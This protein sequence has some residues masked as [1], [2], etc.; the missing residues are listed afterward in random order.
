MNPFEIVLSLPPK[1][2]KHD[3]EI[4]DGKDAID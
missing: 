4:D 3:G 2:R 1:L